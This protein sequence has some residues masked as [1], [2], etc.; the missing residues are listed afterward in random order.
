VHRAVSQTYR[1]PKR[2]RPEHINFAMAQQEESSD[3]VAEKQGKKIKKEKVK[4]RIEPRGLM[5]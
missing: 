4:V 5:V 2:D 3:M 1:S